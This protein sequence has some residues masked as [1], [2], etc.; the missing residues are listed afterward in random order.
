MDKAPKRWLTLEEQKLW[1]AFLGAQ[2]RLTKKL[3]EDLEKS[4]GIDLLTYE[5]FVKLSESNDHSMRMTDLAKSVSANKSR[6]TYRVTQLEIDGLVKRLEVLEDGRGQTCQ[7]TKKG[8]ALIEKYSTVH[9]DG[10]LQN[11]IEP[12]GDGKVKYLTD[13][14]NSIAP[15]VEIEK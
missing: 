8:F 3:N 10:V 14:F 12:I 1:R 7:L 13:V 4:A 5:I 2:F 11:F 15:G 6:L 9:V